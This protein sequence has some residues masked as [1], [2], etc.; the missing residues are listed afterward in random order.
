M[1]V[2]VIY[3][4]IEI[5]LPLFILEMLSHRERTDGFEIIAH[6]PKA[7]DI[8]SNVQEILAKKN[9]GKIQVLFGPDGISFLDESEFEITNLRLQLIKIL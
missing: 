7:N 2:V 5:S 8:F 9:K 3:T 6:N 1:L 4:V